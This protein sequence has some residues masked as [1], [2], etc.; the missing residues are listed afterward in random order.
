[1]LWEFGL[2][3]PLVFAAFPGTTNYQLNSYGFGSG[4]SANSSTSNYSLEGISGE[5]GGPNST[6]ATYTQKPGYVEVQQANVPK[7]TSF[8]NGSGRY[9]NKLHFVIDEQG[10]P[11]DAKYALQ[12][13][14]TSNFSSNINYVKSDL[15]IGPTLVLADYQTFSAW[16]AS[17][18]SNIVGLSPNT[19]YYL[20]AKATQGQFTE[21][22][23]GP[24]VSASTVNPAISFSISPTTLSMGNLLPNTVTDANQSISLQF[25]TNAANGG[26]IF[27]NS[28]YGGLYSTSANHTI[29]SATGDLSSLGYGFGARV[30][31]TGQSSGGPLSAASPYNGITNNVGITD[32]TI[33][34]MVVSAAQ[35]NTG[36]AS[37]LIKAKASSNDPAQT[38]YQEILTMLASA[39]F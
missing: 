22:G 14:T 24:S 21:S 27:I 28:F 38:D 18:G 10:N 31:S 37:V 26:D 11:S 12:I 20:R 29:S 34:R 39:S 17:S 33:R 13:S 15:T 19:T 8:D 23:F 25:D 5:L 6:T 1:M 30:T 2:F 7:I 36:T 35:V 9:Y 3:L 16:G 32:T 4:G